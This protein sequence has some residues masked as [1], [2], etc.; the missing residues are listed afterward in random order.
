MAERMHLTMPRCT[1]ASSCRRHLAYRPGCT[2]PVRSERRSAADRRVRR[3]ASPS[4]PRRPQLSKAKV[5]A[6]R[7]PLGGYRC[8][9]SSA[10][11]LAAAPATQEEDGAY[12]GAAALR[13]V[14]STSKSATSAVP[15]PQTSKNAAFRC[16]SSSVSLTLPAADVRNSGTKTSR[17]LT[18]PVSA[19]NSASRS[20]IALCRA[21]LGG[22]IMQLRQ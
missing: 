13:K 22:P 9:F 6:R 3:R 19:M 2:W 5:V 15:K 11:F 12:R 7:P 20:A 4:A 16:T 1:V 10:A 14:T 18:A 17:R 8:C 21:Y